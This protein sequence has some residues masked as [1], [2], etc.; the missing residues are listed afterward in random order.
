MA[1][2]VTDSFKAK[3]IELEGERILECY[4][5]DLASVLG[6][7]S[8]SSVDKT[9][10]SRSRDGL[11]PTNR[12][13][14]G[15]VLAITETQDNNGSVTIASIDK[16]VIEVDEPLTDEG[17]TAPVLARFTNFTYYINNQHDTIFFKLSGDALVNTA[18][19]Y[20]GADI[21]RE[22]IK[23]ELDKTSVLKI[24][25]QNV[26]RVIE[27][28]IQNRGYLR[29]CDIFV[30]NAYESQFPNG[31]DY[32][33]IGT[34]GETDYL[35][36]VIEKYKIDGVGGNEQAISFECRPKFYLK[37]VKL[38]RRIMDSTHCAWSEEYGGTDCDPDGTNVDY[39][40][41]PTC[42]GT[43]AACRERGNSRR[44]G[45]FPGIPKTAI[46]LR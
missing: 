2:A 31:G 25:I 3:G 6:Y 8:F 44:I 20:K 19:E 4:A 11:F 37:D 36:N 9:I 39:V 12:I 1:H 43:L 27:G 15:D 35:S 5:L 14:V 45:L 42:P 7:V 18:Y 38:P 21:K 26:D 33:Y 28:F 30:M 10:T 24:S 23:S 46:Y 32:R 41:Y 22:T 17:T 13:K 16:R 29:G 40:L 34:S